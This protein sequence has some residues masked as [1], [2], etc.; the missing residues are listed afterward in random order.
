MSW[1]SLP[2]TFSHQ[3]SFQMTYSEQLL[4]IIVNTSD[5]MFLLLR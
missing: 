2:F 4:D 5:V 1:L 3:W